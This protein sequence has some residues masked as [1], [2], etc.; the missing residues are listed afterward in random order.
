[1]PVPSERLF[2]WLAPKWLVLGVAL[3]AFGLLMSFDVRLGIAAGALLGV[4]AVVWLYIAL[5][6][7]SLSGAPSVRTSLVERAQQQEA[8]RRLATTR[9]GSRPQQSP[10]PA[11]RP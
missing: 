4:V 5:R 10:D 6:Y 9:A 3:A 2:G 7:G 11:E 1:M 8:N